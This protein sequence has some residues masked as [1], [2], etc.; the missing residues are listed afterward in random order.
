MLAMVDVRLRR[1]VGLG[2][3]VAL[4]G[5]IACSE[6]E[7][8]EVKDE[9]KAVARTTRAV[10]VHGVDKAKDAIDRV[11]MN[12]VRNAWDSTVEA[13]AG[14]GQAEPDDGLDPLA[15]ASEAIACDEAGERCTVTADFADRARH[16]GS[17][18]AAQVRVRSVSQP[19]R[20]VRVDLVEVGSV[21]ALLGVQAGDVVTHVN[22]V[23][24]G[25]MKDAMMLYVQIRGAHSF[26]VDYLRDEQERVL[27]VDI[28]QPD[29]STLPQAPTP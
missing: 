4:C 18:L 10:V 9:A 6:A 16:H 20:G 26:R 19:A 8:Q 14:A 1:L 27:V 17:A 28:V 29:G 15:G 12:K 3:V 23:P 24:L 7:T 2:S 22:R 11:D 13:V 21:A 5:L 25:S